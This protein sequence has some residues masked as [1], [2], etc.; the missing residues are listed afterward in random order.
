M[1]KDLVK[2][3]ADYDADENADYDADDNADDN[4]DDN[5]DEQLHFKY[6]YN[7]N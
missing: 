2:T 6:G 1:K 7:D 5:A 4:S 3:N